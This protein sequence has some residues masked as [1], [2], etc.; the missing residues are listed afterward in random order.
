MNQSKDLVLSHVFLF[1]LNGSMS[2]ASG[3]GSIS[4]LLHSSLEIEG[5]ETRNGTT[6][7]SCVSRDRVRSPQPYH[8]HSDKTCVG[9]RGAH[10][11]D[12]ADR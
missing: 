5:R 2:F 3:L 6:W 4:P 12:A 8:L 7:C 1:M 9:S 11:Q 10:W